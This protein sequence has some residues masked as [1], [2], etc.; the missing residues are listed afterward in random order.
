MG[1]LNGHEVWLIKETEILP[2]KRTTLHLTEKQVCLTFSSIGL[3][4]G[5]E[6]FN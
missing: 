5:Y 2:Y 6:I 3:I 4:Y 1:T